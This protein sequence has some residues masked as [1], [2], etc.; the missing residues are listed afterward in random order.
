MPDIHNGAEYPSDNV[1]GRFLPF[2]FDNRSAPA[3]LADYLRTLRASSTTHHL[4][5]N[6]TIFSEGDAAERVYII[7]SGAVRI[8]RYL[9]DGRRHVI[10]F[11][12]AGDLLSFFECAH[13]PASAEAA[14]SSTIISYPRR[15]LDR[16]ATENPS[17]RRQV[18]ALVSSN[19]LEAQERLMILSCKTAKERV[20]S[21]LLRL[22]ERSD[23]GAGDILDL[24]MSRQDIADHLGLT[25]ET[26]SRV[27]SALKGDC[28]VAM[29]AAHEI[30]LT[31]VSAL[32]AASAQN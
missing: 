32:R 14:A 2:Q 24:P 4:T 27:L 6:E 29:P 9:P 26:V 19:L 7:V 12:L 20:A 21:F 15:A 8:C 31:N 1:R 22:A 28:V 30:A 16:L 5:R 18:L 23:A 3:T 13:Q 25:I 11:A 17:V 10:D